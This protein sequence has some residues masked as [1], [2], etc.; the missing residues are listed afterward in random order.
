MYRCRRYPQIPHLKALAA[1]IDRLSRPASSNDF[2]ALLDQRR[3]M[4][5]L[6]LELVKLQLPVADADAEVEASAR[7]QRQGGTVLRHPHRVVQWQQHEVGTD[8]HTTGASADGRRQHQRRG[9]IAVVAEMMFR[10]PY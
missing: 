1:E 4:G 7:G 9:R 2:D 10:K 5:E 6:A 3:P 8:T